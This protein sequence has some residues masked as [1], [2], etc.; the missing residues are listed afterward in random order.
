MPRVRFPLRGQGSEYNPLIHNFGKN[1]P[2]APVPAGEPRFLALYL[3]KTNSPALTGIS[4]ELGPLNL[5]RI[6]KG[7]VPLEGLPHM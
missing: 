5:F 1:F 6:A 4:T 7:R 3:N 2:I